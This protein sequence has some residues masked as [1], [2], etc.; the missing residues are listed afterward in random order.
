MVSIFL[1]EAKVV[2]CLEIL[3]CSRLSAVSSRAGSWLSLSGVD[4]P[5]L[6]D[7]SASAISIIGSV[8]TCAFIVAF[9]R[10]QI[11]YID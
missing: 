6:V 1:F 11:R 5:S 7:S 9:E 2:F 3:L 10:P 4:S 8:F